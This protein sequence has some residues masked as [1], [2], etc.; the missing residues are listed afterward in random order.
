[1]FQFYLLSTNIDYDSVLI[2]RGH[3][4]ARHNKKIIILPNTFLIDRF[5]Q[6]LSNEGAAEYF[7]S[8]V[9]FD[10]NDNLVASKGELL[11][12]FEAIIL[13]LFRCYFIKRLPVLEVNFE[14]T[15]S[16]YLKKK[17]WIKSSLRSKEFVQYKKYA[18]RYDARKVL[19]LDTEALS[20]FVV[21]SCRELFFP[22]FTIP[23]L[24][25]KP[26]DDNVFLVTY[27]DELLAQE[28]KNLA[29]DAGLYIR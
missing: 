4:E 14:E 18:Q 16:C 20:F 5:S 27:E 17:P 12:E 1:M 24:S 28:L 11:L 10:K 21:I 7:A 6:L 29:N 3:N 9:R 19:H 25:I 23:G 8:F 22:T 2:R 13:K 26:C 15:L